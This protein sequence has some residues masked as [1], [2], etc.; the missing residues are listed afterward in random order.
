M[1]LL[2][3]PLL[4]VTHWCVAVQVYR[5]KYIETTIK[6]V[7]PIVRVDVTN[8]IDLIERH[9][10]PTEVILYLEVWESHLFYVHKSFVELFL[11]SF[12]CT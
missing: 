1:S 8:L 2:L 4:T 3:Y 6:E 10:N 12:L 11:K 7:A 9:V 5:K